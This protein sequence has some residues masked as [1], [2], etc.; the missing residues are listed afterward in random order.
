MR[1]FLLGLSLLFTLP[2]A[3]GADSLASDSPAVRTW[4][5]QGSTMKARLLR[6]E[7]NSISVKMASDGWVTKFWLDQ[8][9]AEDQN[10]VREWKSRGFGEP[11]K[12]VTVP[13]NVDWPLE[14]SPNLNFPTEP[15]S[16]RGGVWV[17]ET[18]NYQYRSD[19]KLAEDL[20][21]EYAKWFEGTYAAIR[22]MP[23]Q[24][25]M[26][27][28]SEKFVVKLFR[29][30]SDY[31]RAGGLQG[32]SGSY[33]P[34]TKEI[35]V[36]LSS[37][38]V[39]LW[40]EQIAL[41]RRTFDSK[42]L[43]HEITH[44]VMHYWIQVLPVWFIEG[45][46]EYMSCVP[47][48]GVWYD[49]ENI[50]EGIRKHLEESYNFPPTREG[51][52]KVD[53]VPLRDLMAINH[54]QW[55]E[56][57]KRGQASANY[58]SALLMVYYFAHLDD[59]GAEEVSPLVRY[60]KLTRTGRDEREHFVATYNQAVE[61]YKAELTEFNEQVDNYNAALL[62]Y[63]EQASSYNEQVRI[64]NDQVRKRIP[65]EERVQLGLPPVL[66]K[67][68]LPPEKPII[69]TQNPQV[70]EVDLSEAE[71]EARQ[72]LLRGRSPEELWK[73]MEEAFALER[74][75]IREVGPSS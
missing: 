58:C 61:R 50:E 3:T 69:L 33:I 62:M 59:Q 75:W 67:R 25:N 20:F 31:L 18:P 9:S 64:H 16:N 27:P 43:V 47:F 38:G 53:M 1:Q 70:S 72:V 71:N 28:P 11:P 48:N 45:M 54:E 7:P 10:Y 41:D 21:L 73:A 5:Y 40:G 42:P 36:P 74:I 60:L 44:Q 8:L 63:R 17:Y 39:K 51:V 26:E 4:N 66:P 15:V 55:A 2:C 13:A 32:S 68:P 65:S 35:L 49:F 22:Q 46:A 56:A 37:L 12:P 52:Y 29:G 57:L 23:L 24:L 14:V 30:Q 34:K 19:V 6:I